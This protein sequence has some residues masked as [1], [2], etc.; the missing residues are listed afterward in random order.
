MFS[1]P[2]LLPT[3]AFLTWAY[4][5]INIMSN[6]FNK[7]LKYLLEPKVN[8]L[9]ENPQGARY[10]AINISKTKALLIGVFLVPIRFLSAISILA[11]A[12][13]I[14]YCIRY[15]FGGEKNNFH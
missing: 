2:L 1:L 14:T 9:R 3:L 11:F 8:L 13:C 4:F 12:H 10:D 15:S 6:A 5:Y 7:S